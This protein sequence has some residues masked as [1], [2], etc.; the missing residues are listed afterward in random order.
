MLY[1]LGLFAVI[2][3]AAFYLADAP[4]QDEDT[5]AEMKAYPDLNIQDFKL[6]MKRLKKLVHSKFD[7]EDEFMGPRGGINKHTASGNKIYS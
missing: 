4:A 6:H 5:R 2:G 7:G 1:L 3:S